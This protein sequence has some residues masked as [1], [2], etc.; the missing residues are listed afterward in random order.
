MFM[1]EKSPIK[2]SQE[3]TAPGQ[4]IAPIRHQ[5]AVQELHQDELMFQI[6]PLEPTDFLPQSV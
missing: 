1:P 4:M 6:L 2:Q 5:H 3:R